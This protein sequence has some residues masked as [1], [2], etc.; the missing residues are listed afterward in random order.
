MGALYQLQ[1]PGKAWVGMTVLI[2]GPYD[3]YGKVISLRADGYHL[4]RG[5]GHRNPDGERHVR[6]R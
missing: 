4:I 5:L 3:K 6:T 1:V 2:D